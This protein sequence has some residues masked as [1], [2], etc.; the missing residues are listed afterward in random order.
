[1]NDDASADHDAYC[2]GDGVPRAPQAAADGPVVRT[3]PG[4]A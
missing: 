3:G 4:P 2:R 1:V